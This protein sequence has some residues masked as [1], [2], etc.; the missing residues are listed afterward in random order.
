M[1]D[2]T[3]GE[4]HIKQAADRTLSF[5]PNDYAQLYQ[6]YYSIR[7]LL[8]GDVVLQLCSFTH[9]GT[10]PEAVTAHSGPL[11]FYAVS[12]RNNPSKDLYA[13]RVHAVVFDVCKP[14]YGGS[15]EREGKKTIL[16]IRRPS[17]SFNPTLLTSY[18]AIPPADNMTVYDR[19]TDFG[20][21]VQPTD[22]Y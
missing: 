8:R 15:P 18:L 21:Y 12:F 7:S 17:F 9:C 10:T 11:R 1:E 4:I 14:G 3:Q 19:N 2:Y 5:S 13:D 20:G 16:E 6:R 22:A